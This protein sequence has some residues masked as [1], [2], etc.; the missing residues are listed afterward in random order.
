M[1]NSKYVGKHFQ[2]SPKDKND[3]VMSLSR[4]I[5]QL[6]TIRMDV[7]NDNACDQSL[8]QILAARGGLSKIA[9]EMVGRGVLD[10]KDTYSKEEFETILKNILKL[11]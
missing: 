2:F 3:L 10:C 4:I 1:N 9:K 7:E 11:D 8:T 5:G 6:Q